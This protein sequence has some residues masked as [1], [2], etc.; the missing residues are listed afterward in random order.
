MLTFGGMEFIKPLESLRA[1]HRSTFGGKAAYLGELLG[2]GV[3]VPAGFAISVDALKQITTAANLTP[4]ISAAL[5]RLRKNP[6]DI[7]TISEELTGLIRS[8]EVHAD[9]ISSLCAAFDRLG[10][11]SVAVRSSAPEEDGAHSSWAGQFD[12]FLGVRRDDL[13]A[14]VKSCWA[15]LYGVRALS[16]RLLRS[17]EVGSPSIAV[18]VQALIP[19]EVS[20][21]VFSIDPVSGRKDRMVVE[22]VRGLGEGL[23]SGEL[24]PSR[25]TVGKSNLEVVERIEVVQDRAIVPLPTGGSEWKKL[26]DQSPVILP[27][28]AL[29]ELCRGVMKLESIF[30]FPVDVEWCLEN[31]LVYFV[32]TRPVT[33]MGNDE[34][35]ALL[36]SFAAEAGAFEFQWGERHPIISAE[37]WFDSYPRYRHLPANECRRGF[38][39]SDGGYITTYFH[40][41]GFAEARAQ[42]KALCD[43]ELF[44]EYLE[45][46][47]EVRAQFSAVRADCRATDL[48]TAPDSVLADLFRR[49]QESFETVYALYRLS[50]HEYTEY[51]AD[52]LKRRLAEFFPDTAEC[53]AAFITATSITERDIVK[54]EEASVYQ[55][56]LLP[57]ISEG[58]LEKHR[59]EF[60]WLFFNTF[61]FGL[62]NR[63]LIDRI[64]ALREIPETERRKHLEDMGRELGSAKVKQREL[65][66]K[67]ADPEVERIGL[68][69]SELALDRYRLKAFW[70]GA[71]FTF[72]PLFQEIA[73]RAGLEIEEFLNSYRP[74]DIIR[75]LENGTIV[76]E[77]VRQKRKDAYLVYLHDEECRW[78]EG[79]EARAIFST[80]VPARAPDETSNAAGLKGDIANTGRAA[81]TARIVRVE[82]IKQLLKDIER[83][84]EGE[85]LVTTMT[86]PTML[87]LVRKAAAIVTNEGGITSHASVLAREMK[88]PCIVGTKTATEFFQDGDRI[89]VDAYSGRVWKIIE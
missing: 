20:G 53:E 48:P 18:V 7:E 69:F 55:L 52:H 12:T 6:A 60:S 84:Q 34:S 70:G 49:Q 56:S 4:S 45:R 15:S 71:T 64:Q 47:R 50:Q 39:F 44:E 89:E 11:P 77:N 27:A 76:P 8:A 66:S 38:S 5:E 65:F 81:G 61:D 41:P 19:S 59:S 30:G 13:I 79:D 29:A 73:K 43:P 23:V 32:Q 57:N 40:V 36:E 63:F 26:A 10:A 72:L 85:I 78:F 3:R 83:F 17:G 37:C 14:S 1:E 62:A 42:G 86:Q 28:S 54:D 46:S 31:S 9:I 68:M 58:A 74:A 25:Y 21:V 33:A 80:L 16:Y 67:L 22:C 35:R 87:T 82:G 51:A 88:I 24:S 75:F 2:Y